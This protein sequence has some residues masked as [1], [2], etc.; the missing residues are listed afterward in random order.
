VLFVFALNTMV[1]SVALGQGVIPGGE[2]P[3]AGVMAEEAPEEPEK[4]SS[5]WGWLIGIGA[6]VAAG[7]GGYALAEDDSDDDEGGGDAAAEGAAAAAAAAEAAAAEEEEGFANVVF[8]TGQFSATT[9]P[10]G[11]LPALLPSITFSMPQG[12]FPGGVRDYVGSDGSTGQGG[13]YEQVSDLS[14]FIKVD[15]VFYLGK[16][17]VQSWDAIRLENGTML[18]AVGDGGAYVQKVAK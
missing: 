8:L 2:D 12:D 6:A 15:D 18:Y 5:L 1:S 7:V 11:W 10:S 3:G 14:V 16:A 9:R 17:T 4:G 13:D